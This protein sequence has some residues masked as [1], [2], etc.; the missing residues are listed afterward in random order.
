[1]SP[2]KHGKRH[3]LVLYKTAMNQ[4]WPPFFWLGLLLGIL[5]LI[6]GRYLP[7]IEF[8]VPFLPLPMSAALYLGI[9]VSVFVVVY[10]FITRNMGTIQ[11]RSDY[12]R[13]SAPLLTVKISYRRVRRNHPTQIGQIFPPGKTK[14]AIRRLVEPYDGM[15]AVVLHLKGYPISPALLRFIFGPTLLLPTG[16]GLVL[17]VDDWMVLSTEIDGAYGVWQTN[18]LRPNTHMEKGYGLLQ[19]TK[20][21]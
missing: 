16:Q 15:T 2:T 8:Q 14:N 10:I 17:L 13:L 4:K 5:A 9:L 11:A 21:K 1:M 20:K 12:I 6:S 19:G 7:Y 3:K 18:Q